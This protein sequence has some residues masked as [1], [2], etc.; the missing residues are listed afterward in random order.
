MLKSL[1]AATL[2]LSGNAFAQAAAAPAQNP[3]LQFLPLVV[4]FVIF[5]FLMIR[6]QK[7]KFDQEQE[8]ISKLAKGDEIYT[9]SGLIGTIYGMTDTVVTVEVSEGVRFK[10]LKNQIAGLYKTLTETA[11][12]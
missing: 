5:Y 2:L 1:L 4:V 12:K 11:K 6:P 3:L 8:L 7:K 10:V 9:K